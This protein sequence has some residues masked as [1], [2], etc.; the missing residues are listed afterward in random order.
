[1]IP[2]KMIKYTTASRALLYLRGP[3]VS[4]DWNLNIP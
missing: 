3:P 2:A 1:M 4:V